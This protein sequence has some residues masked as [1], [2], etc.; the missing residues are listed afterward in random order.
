MIVFLG[1]SGS[2]VK[3]DRRNTTSESWLTGN[4]A[5]W[6]PEEKGEGKFHYCVRLFLFDLD[7]LYTGKVA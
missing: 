5:M 7:F 2:P 3:W 1:S 4:M 6:S